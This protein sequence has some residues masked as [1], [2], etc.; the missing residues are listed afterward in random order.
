MTLTTPEELLV[1]SKRRLQVADHFL[2]QTYQY[3]QDPK[4]LVNVLEGVLLAVEELI[5]ATLI[6]ERELGAVHAYQDNIAAKITLLKGS[7]AKKYDLSHVD[8]AMITEMQELI[9]GH[10][11]STVEFAR[12]GSYV[13]A[14]KDFS[15]STVN[16]EKIKTYLNRTKTLYTKIHDRLTRDTTVSQ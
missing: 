14:S 8:I 4:I 3:V 13:M 16:V 9:H 10:K 6:H 1:S 2:T 7:L 5:D 12:K 11:E 15:L